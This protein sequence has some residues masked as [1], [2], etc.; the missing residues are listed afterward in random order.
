VNTLVPDVTVPVLA[1]SVPGPLSH[2]TVCPTPPDAQLKV[3]SPA[4]TVSGVGR[5][6][7]FATVMVVE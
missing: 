7:L 3:T 5:N 6:V 4:G 2:E 1:G